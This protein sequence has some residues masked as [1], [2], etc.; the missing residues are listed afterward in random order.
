M[1]HTEYSQ[2]AGILLLILNFIAIGIQTKK[3]H[4]SLCYDL[5]AVGS[6]LVWLSYWPPFFREG[7]PIFYVFSLYFAFITAFLSLLFK[8]QKESMSIDEIKNLQMLAN[9]RLASPLV[10]LT[11]VIMSLA[12]PEHFL[13]FP[14]AI[15]LLIIRFSLT[16]CL[17]TK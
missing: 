14:V 17:Y 9:Y 5:F 13:L 8:A 12:F 15:T 1:F 2:Y 3:I 7:S 6:I 10:F 11:V 16:D 4:F